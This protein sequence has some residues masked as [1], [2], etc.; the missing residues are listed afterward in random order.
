MQ[1]ERYYTRRHRSGV[2]P[3]E[4]TEKLTGIRGQE[5]EIAREMHALGIFL[6]YRALA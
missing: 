3:L 6:N 2:Q 4:R 5:K 1:E